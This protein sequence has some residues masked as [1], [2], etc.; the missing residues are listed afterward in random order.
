MNVRPKIQVEAEPIVR[1]A[2]P[3]R[4]ASYWPVLPPTFVGIL[5]LGLFMLLARSDTHANPLY[6]DI[7]QMAGS[8]AAARLYLAAAGLFLVLAA[9]A[10]LFASIL[11]ITRRSTTFEL[12]VNFALAIGLMLA[13]EF[14]AHLFA[15]SLLSDLGLGIFRDTVGRLWTG[16]DPSACPR[17]VESFVPQ[18]GIGICGLGYLQLVVECGGVL[19]AA[20]LA[21]AA[22][23]IAALLEDGHSTGAPVEPAQRSA[24]LVIG[25]AGT[26]ATATITL[27]KAWAYLPLSFFPVTNPPVVNPVMDG[28]RATVAGFENF[29]AIFFCLLVAA[30]ALPAMARDVGPNIGRGDEHRTRRSPAEWIVIGAAVAAPLIAIHYTVLTNL[31]RPHL[32]GT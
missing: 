26:A 8:E 2:A 22:V 6:W 10:S 12:A 13:F 25:L 18:S 29:V 27:L 11:A 7:A 19:L 31:I 32:L 30:I 21:F 15:R 23:A 28:F 1:A 14:A 16:S 17:L 24:L 5:G 9:G 3:R 20:S 4:V